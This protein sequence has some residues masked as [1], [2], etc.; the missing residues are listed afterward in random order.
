MQCYSHPTGD[1]ALRWLL[2]TAILLAAS[3]ALG[4]V[5]Y[6][7]ATVAMPA[8]LLWSPAYRGV[9]AAIAR[10]HHW[11][12]RSWAALLSCM[13]RLLAARRPAST[14]ARWLPLSA[15]Q[16]TRSLLLAAS[17]FLR[18]PPAVA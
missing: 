3:P 1:R 12:T 18:A 15:T 5:C 4:I 16:S 9:L 17:S 11:V 10:V 13:V 14:T 7:G 2:M 8:A 6:L